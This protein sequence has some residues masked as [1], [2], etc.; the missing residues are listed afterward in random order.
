MGRP[1]PI[2][3]MGR[4]LHPMLKPPARSPTGFSRLPVLGWSEAP[5]LC[6]RSWQESIPGRC[7]DSGPR[8][9]GLGSSERDGSCAD[10]G[11]RVRGAR[12]GD[13]GKKDS[14]GRS[15]LERSCLHLT[16]LNWPNI[17]SSVQPKGSAPQPREA[18]PGSHGA[19]NSCFAPQLPPLPLRPALSCLPHHASLWGLWAWRRQKTGYQASCIWMSHGFWPT[20]SQ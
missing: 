1:Q 15:D 2:S 6:R 13:H 12:D 19:S 18:C 5:A 8:C 20:H 11:C 16:H 14:S 7:W 9:L 4:G 17:P 3:G 10:Q